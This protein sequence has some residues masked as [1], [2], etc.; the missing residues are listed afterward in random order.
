MSDR[1]GIEALK[2]H[3]STLPEYPW[4]EP[5]Q[6][7]VERDCCSAR[8]GIPQRAVSPRT[9]VGV[10]QAADEEVVVGGADVDVAVE[11]IVAE[12]GV[13]VTAEEVEMLSTAVDSGVLDKLGGCAAGDRRRRRRTGA[14]GTVASMQCHSSS[15][16]RLRTR[17]SPP[18]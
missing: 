3:V 17:T 14:G 1:S 10:A 6:F 18:R 13:V 2:P 7:T 8:P 4:S 9:A 11:G 16:P 12:E 5:R 15:G